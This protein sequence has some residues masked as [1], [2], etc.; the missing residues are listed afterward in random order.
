M[1]IIPP[2]EYAPA[3]QQQKGD[4]DFCGRQWVSVSHWG[5]L[6]VTT[7]SFQTNDITV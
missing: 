1:L 6:G 7:E 3:P 4:T 5:Q 2:G